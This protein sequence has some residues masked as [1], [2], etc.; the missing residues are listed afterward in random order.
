MLAADSI[1]FLRWQLQ[2]RHFPGLA[3]VGRLMRERGPHHAATILRDVSRSKRDGL[4][5][6][7]A[8]ERLTKTAQFFLELVVAPLLLRA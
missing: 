5:A 7:F 3:K 2:K 6:A 1:N 4:H 8:P